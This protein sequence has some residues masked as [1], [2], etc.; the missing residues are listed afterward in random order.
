MIVICDND[1]VDSTL[2]DLL[3]CLVLVNMK[4]NGNQTYITPLVLA[5]H[6]QV[7]I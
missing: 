3:N 6:P 4:Y 7:L 2:N 5:R 1:T